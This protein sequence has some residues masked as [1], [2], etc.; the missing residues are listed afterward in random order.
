[1]TTPLHPP[2][3]GGLYYI[4]YNYYLKYSNGTT[5]LPHYC[6]F[7]APLSK[8]RSGKPPFPLENCIVSAVVR[9]WKN[10]CF[11]SR[12]SIGTTIVSTGTIIAISMLSCAAYYSMSEIETI[13]DYEAYHARRYKH[14]LD[15]IERYYDSR[16]KIA[17]FGASVEYDI[18]KKAF[19]SSTVTPYG[20]LIPPQVVPI[21]ELQI[22][23][24]N[25]SVSVSERYD[26][27][28][29]CEVVEH[30]TRPFAE[31][32]N[33]LLECCDVVIIQTPNSM[34]LFNRIACLIGRSPWQHVKI[35]NQNA[36]HIY[37][38]TYN[39]LTEGLP[40][41][42][43]RGVNYFGKPSLR[44]LSYNL[45]CTLLPVTFRDGFTIVYRK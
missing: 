31:V 8:T 35:Q 41:E 9:Q 17:I 3:Q 37:E 26:I 44:R 23:D 14:L 13:E 6:P 4:I 11:L 15:T 40:V 10:L 34:C 7:V 32:L 27:G 25:Q 19:P 20:S 42:D 29:C 24:L 2:S 21:N 5:D 39:E 38:Y 1:M 45:L 16:M 33:D 28:I 12:F 43:V 30:L 36:E 22:I 18:V